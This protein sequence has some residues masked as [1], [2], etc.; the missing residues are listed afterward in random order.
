M[1]FLR[2]GLSKTHREARRRKKKQG[3]G[4]LDVEIKE[5]NLK[6]FLK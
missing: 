3:G 6:W 4:K 2:N 1:N 5:G